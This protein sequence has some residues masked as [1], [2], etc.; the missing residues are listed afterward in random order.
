[1]LLSTKSSYCIQSIRSYSVKKLKKRPKLLGIYSSLPCEL[2]RVNSTEKVILRDYD[3]Q[4]AQNRSSYD[5]ILDPNGLVQP[6]PSTGLFERPNGMSLRPNGPF[7]QEIIRRF[8]NSQTTIYKLPKGL[9]LKGR[10]LTCLWEHSDHHSV[11]T[12]V[13]IKLEELNRKLTEM[14]IKEGEKMSKD[15]FLERYSFDDCI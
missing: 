10:Q 3:T 5:L 11:Q 8:N 9:D 6:S 13:P 14:C 2:F 4:M 12:I 15:E 1:M 7:L